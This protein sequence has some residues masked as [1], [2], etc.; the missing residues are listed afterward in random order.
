MNWF[1]RLR[2]K[3]S[4]VQGSGSAFQRAAAHN[5]RLDNARAKLSTLAAAARDTDNQ[6][7]SLSAMAGAVHAD[8][9]ALHQKIQ[10]LE[11]LL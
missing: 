4:G 8:R 9:D 10:T 11:A 1:Y 2:N 7:A 6:I 5:D 3:L